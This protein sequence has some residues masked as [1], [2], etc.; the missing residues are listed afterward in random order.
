M[1]KRNM[2]RKVRAF[3]TAYARG[4]MELE[5]IRQSLV[6]W[7]GHAKHGNTYNLR[8]RVSRELVITREAGD[9]NRENS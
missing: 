9:R 2:L 8:R 3:K 5:Q 4:D 6:A 1:S 7:S